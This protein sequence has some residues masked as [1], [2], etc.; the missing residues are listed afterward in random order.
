MLVLTLKKIMD[1]DEI[2][3]SFDLIEKQITNEEMP[4]ILFNE[5]REMKLSNNNKIIIITIILILIVFI[6]SKIFYL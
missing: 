3:S 1:F 5:I 4:K 2:D 6:R